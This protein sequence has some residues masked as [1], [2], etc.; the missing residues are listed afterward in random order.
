MVRGFFGVIAGCIVLSILLF[1]GMSAAFVGM[2]TEGAF[3][4]ESY[5][6]TTKWTLV[7]VGVWF[8]AAILGG[9]T[10]A[11][12]ARSC[13][14]PLVLACFVLV[15]SILLAI[16]AMMTGEQEVKI[17]DAEV[18]NFDAFKEA[19]TPAWI[20]LLNPLIGAAGVM[21]GGRLRGTR[22]AVAPK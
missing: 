16:P 13:R 22:G 20:A 7:A 10:C 11:A 12:I 21:A 17:R 4:P 5:D 6:V 1:A 19:K 8:L 3:K 2:G 9:Y 18:S 14:A 15:F